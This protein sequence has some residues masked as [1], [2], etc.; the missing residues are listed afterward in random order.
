[1]G[2]TQKKKHTTKTMRA[3]V[4]FAIIGL[5]L[6]ALHRV[7]I[8]KVKKD[9]KLGMTK[10][11]GVQGC[12]KEDLSQFMDAQWWGPITL[13]TPAQNFNVCFDTGSSNLWVPA[14]GVNF[15]GLF[16]NKFHHENSSSYTENGDEMEI[17]YGSGSI[18]G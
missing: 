10:L 7:P 8:Q 17:Q 5:S 15:W 14:S 3:I 18:K 4:L 12:S 9:N 2:I 16:K 1:M 11:G 6:S 13:G